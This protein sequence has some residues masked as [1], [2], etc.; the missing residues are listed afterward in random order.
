MANPTIPFNLHVL[1]VEDNLVNQMIA[2]KV[3]EKLG[4]SVKA[5]DN[6][7]KALE[8]LAQEQFDLVLMDCMMPEMDGYEATRQ[9][10]VSGKPY[11]D[12]PVI[13]FTANEA[14][15]DQQ[16]CKQ[17]GMNDFIHKPVSL[18]EMQK[19][20]ARWQQVIYLGG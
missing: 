1:V 11:A 6:G 16:S 5:V 7:I 20:L 15:N 4:C 18:P 19:L 17:A 9:I 14:E 8:V 10:R 3:L 12:I 2:R 13:A